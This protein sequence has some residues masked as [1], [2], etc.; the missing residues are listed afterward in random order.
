MPSRSTL[1]RRVNGKGYNRVFL[2]VGVDAC[3]TESVY[4]ALG[5][6]GSSISA[7]RRYVTRTRPPHSDSIRAV[8][9]AD[10]VVAPVMMATGPVRSKSA[11]GTAHA[12]PESYE[13]SA[14]STA[15][16]ARWMRRLGNCGGEAGVAGKRE[17]ADRRDGQDARS[18]GPPRAS[19][20]LRER[21]QTLVLLSPL[22]QVPTSDGGP[23]AAVER[24]I[25]KA[26]A[27]CRVLPFN[28]STG[29]CA[30]QGRSRSLWLAR[31][32]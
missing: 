13:G 7:S 32:I 15:W 8:A 12:G 23:I 9:G 22:L 17:A 29:A 20:F 18:A 5:K 25:D 16:H 30:V 1:D 11:I 27:C 24:L 28:C 31:E 21:G 6:P 3:R 2:Q 26:V 10:A 19:S 4:C 14:R